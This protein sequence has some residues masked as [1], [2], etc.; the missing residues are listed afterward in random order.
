MPPVRGQPGA[1]PRTFIFRLLNF[2]DWDLA[3]REARKVE[4]LRF[5]NAKLMLF[6][7]YSVDT[8][9]LWRT[10]D[11]IKAQLRTRGLNYSMLFPARLRVVDG[12]STRYFTS[13]EEASKWLDTLPQAR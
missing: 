12:E 11:H 10:F 1:P 3:L 5:E 7:D 2:R 9:R 8:E 13:L 6:P 4:E